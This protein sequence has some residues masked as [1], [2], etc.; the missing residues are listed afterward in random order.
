VTLG[1]TVGALPGTRQG[2]Q[3]SMRNRLNA[4]DN[5]M[6]FPVLA[7]SGAGDGNVVIVEFIQVRIDNFRAGSASR[8]D[9]FDIQ[10][11]ASAVSSNDFASADE[12][13]GINSVQ[14]VRLT[15]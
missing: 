1:Q 2:W 5:E 10:I 9:E 4:G 3:Q 7:P 12:G 13:L 15:E 14:G 11:I 8:Q 6:T